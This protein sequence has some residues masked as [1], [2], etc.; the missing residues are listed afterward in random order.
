V[1]YVL[2]AFK[3]K[4]TKGI[5]TPKP[6]IELIRARHKAARDLHAEREQP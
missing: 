3:K 5:G 2:H 1:V 6:D 4:S